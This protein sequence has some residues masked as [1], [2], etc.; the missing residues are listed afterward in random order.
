M[1]FAGKPTSHRLLSAGN[2]VVVN[3]SWFEKHGVKD[4]RVRR[5]PL[6]KLMVISKYYSTNNLMKYQKNSTTKCKLNQ[7]FSGNILWIM[8]F[9]TP[10]NKGEFGKKVSRNT[11]KCRHHCKWTESYDDIVETRIHLFYSDQRCVVVLSMQ[12]KW[13]KFVKHTVQLLYFSIE[14]AIEST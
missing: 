9:L 2:F 7:L 1:S 6:T 10:E 12:N 4:A 11:K 8:F 14:K 3:S 5:F 13:S